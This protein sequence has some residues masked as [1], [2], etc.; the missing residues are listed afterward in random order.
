L[1]M[2]FSNVREEEREEL[3]YWG[4]LTQIDEEPFRLSIDLGDLDADAGGGAKLRLHF[5]GWSSLPRDRVDAAFDHHVEVRIN[6]EPAGF[7]EWDNRHG[8]ELLELLE[9]PAS[10]LKPGRNDLTVRVVP[11]RF[12]GQKA[13]QVDVVLLNWVEVAYPASRRVRAGQT[14]LALAKPAPQGCVEFDVEPGSVLAV[15][16][17]D[18]TRIAVAAGSDRL[19]V[20]AGTAWPAGRPFDLVLDEAYFRPA[21]IVVDRPGGL[22]V[23]DRQA[24]YVMVAHPRLI[25]AVEPLAEFHRERGLSV[26]VVD[27]NDVY[28]EFNHGVVHPRAIRAF[29]AHAYQHWGSPA[30]RYVLLVGDASWDSGGSIEQRDYADKVFRQPHRSRWPRNRYTPYTTEPDL[31]HRN[32]IPTWGAGTRD[33]QAANDNWFVAVDGDDDLPEM[34]IG[35]LPVT[36]PEEIAAIVQKTVRYASEAELGPWRRRILWVTNEQP[37]YQTRSDRLAERLG[38]RGFAPVRVYPVPEERSNLAHQTTLREAFDEGQLIVHFIGHGGRYIWRTGPP[39]LDKNHDLFTLDDLDDLVSNGR[40]PIVVSMTCYSAPFDHPDADSIGEKFLRLPGRGAVAVVAASWRNVPSVEVSALLLDSL[41]RPG[42]VGEAFLRAKRE[43]G[44]AEFV[45]QY[46]LLG[47]PALPVALPGLD[48]DVRLD[49]GDLTAVRAEVGDPEFNGRAIVEWVGPGEEILHTEQRRINGG[50]VAASFGGDP[51]RIG[52]LVGV[53]VYVWDEA[54]GLD[55]V[56]GLSLTSD[57]TA[58]QGDTD[59]PSVSRPTGHRVRGAG[60]ERER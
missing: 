10:Y 2:R 22:A 48:V 11:R 14:R 12:G 15:Y 37:Y 8:G 33:G 21:G 13:A 17:G 43:G 55:G 45:S 50:R 24:D 27:V 53:R 42:T 46:N 1:R 18:G 31:G 25:E 38:S 7:A 28:D 6:G 51:G 54:R 52:E 5:R 29:L 9:L 47:D 4:R 41:T 36:E 3:W 23:D 30:P 26:A 58:R 34:A 16:R 60:A 20:R 49:P 35:R 59:D 40:L 32:L 39:D 57:G 19:A 56:G 44:N